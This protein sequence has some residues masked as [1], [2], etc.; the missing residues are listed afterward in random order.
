MG[1]YGLVGHPGV[2]IWIIGALLIHAVYFDQSHQ[3]WDW[4][5]LCSLINLI[6]DG[7]DSRC[8]KSLN[9]ILK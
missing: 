8:V 5:T 9:E 6:R 2:F 1:H 3:G 4:F 7:I